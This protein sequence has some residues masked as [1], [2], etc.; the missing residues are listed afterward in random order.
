MAAIGRTVAGL[1][2][3]I[4]NIL[5]GVRGGA[6]VINSAVKKEDLGL[7]QKG[8]NM[9]ERNI[10]QIAHIVQDMLIYSRDRTPTL[11]AVDPNELLEDVLELMEEKARISGVRITR[12]MEPDRGD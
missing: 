5:T 7:V 11:E 8:W 1:A 6:Y 12:R 9:V 4:K 2:H 10:D 3:Y